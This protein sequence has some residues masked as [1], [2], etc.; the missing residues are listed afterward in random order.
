MKRAALQ[1]SIRRGLSVALA[2]RQGLRGAELLIF[3]TEAM[4]TPVV[5]RTAAEILLTI[6]AEHPGAIEP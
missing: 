5:V 6:E 2:K 1:E 3:A 4:T